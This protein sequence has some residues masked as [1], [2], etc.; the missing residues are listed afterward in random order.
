MID[1]VY[2][3]QAIQAME[4]LP[5]EKQEELLSLATFDKPEEKCNFIIN[6]LL[7]MCENLQKL[8]LLQSSMMEASSAEVFAALNHRK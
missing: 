1:L 7:T 6:H 2:H 5:M 3:Q 8:P 4:F